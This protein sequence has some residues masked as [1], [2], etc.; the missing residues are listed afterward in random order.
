MKRHL[1]FDPRW[2]GTSIHDYNWHFHRQLLNRYGVVLGPG[3]YSQMVRDIK[4]G[5]APVIEQKTRR[6][7]IY[8]VRIHKQFERV[9][10]LSDGKQ[11]LTAW[12][13]DRRLMEKR[14]MLGHQ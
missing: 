2:E 11:L 14:R 13:P 12:P 7:A 5:R 6:T 1:E 9:F 10:I 4:S 8:W 3:E